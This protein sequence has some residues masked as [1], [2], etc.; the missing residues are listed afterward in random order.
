MLGKDAYTGAGSQH[1]VKS[2]WIGFDTTG[3]EFCGAH[4]SAF[5]ERVWNV[6]ARN[7]REHSGYPAPH[8]HLHYYRFSGRRLW[9]GA[10]GLHVRSSVGFSILIV[11]SGGRVYTH[12]LRS[13]NDSAGVYF[14]ASYMALANKRSF[15][16]IHFWN[17]AGR[18]FSCAESTP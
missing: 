17:A 12:L 7:F 1:T 6:N 9:R 14:A 8:D 4:R 15:K 13:K 5:L 18:K 16:T 2:I 10:G 11:A 3:D